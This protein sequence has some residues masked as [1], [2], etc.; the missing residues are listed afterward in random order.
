MK[1]FE[2]DDTVGSHFSLLD[3]LL[4]LCIRLHS[5]YEFIYAPAA[6]HIHTQT[7]MQTHWKVATLSLSP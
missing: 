2:E 3:S 7:H 6:G 1:S 4:S 5:K